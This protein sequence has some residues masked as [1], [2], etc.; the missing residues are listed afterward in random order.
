MP[1]EAK[2][3]ISVINKNKGATADA[4]AI[5]ETTSGAIS[6][7]PKLVVDNRNNLTQTM[8]DENRLNLDRSVLEGIYQ[9]A[10][11]DL[12]NN[13]NIVRLFPDIELC[14]QILVSSILSPKKMTDIQLIYSLDK[15]MG[16]LPNVSSK[17]L[18]AIEEHIETEYKLEDLLPDIVR[19][20]LFDSGSYCMAVIP[21]ASVDELINADIVSSL[22]TEAYQV[23]ADKLLTE[24]TASA[25]IITHTPVERLTAGLPMPQKSLMDMMLGNSQIRITD[26]C[27]LLQFSS[28]KEKV[29]ASL[30]KKSMRSG[31]GFAAESADRINY[32]DV[33]RQRQVGTAVS[34]VSIVKDK[35]QTKRKSIG[36][37]MVVKFPAE[38]TIPVSIPGNE[39]EHIGYLVLL[40]ENGKPLD[41]N[42]NSDV[43]N[44]ATG[45]Y[46]QVNQSAASPIQT[47]YR[48]LILDETSPA[49]SN[50]LYH[51]Y[52]TVLEKQLYETVKSSLYG[53]NVKIAQTNDIYFMMYCRA[54]ADQ[55]TNI[56][57]I[58]KE[59][60]V[61]FSFYYTDLGIG[62]SLL[63]NLT[64]LSSL[65]AI[66]LFSRVMAEAKNAIDVT[67]V[68]IQLD[69]RDP[70]PRKTIKA[71]QD[72]VMKLRAGFFP[73][74][75]NNPT[76]L[77]QWIQR[78]GLRFGYSG[79]PDLPD[80][81]IDF[82]T[83]KIDHVS[84]SGETEENLRKQTIQALGLPPEVVDNAFSPE[85]ATS[86]VSNNMLLAKRVMIYRKKLC[87]DLKKM[88]GMFI[89]M[90]EML[91]DTLRGMIGE[92]LQEITPTL[93]EDQKALAQ[94]DK[95]T[96]IEQY[97]DRMAEA[98]DV[99]LP[100]AENTNLLNLTQEFEV[101]K[102]GL[103][104]V[105]DSILSTD[106]FAEDIAG[107]FNAHVD[108]V[109]NIFIHHLLRQ[110]CANNNYYPEALAFTNNVKEEVD[111]MI[112]VLTAHLNG[113]IRN[114]SLL[115]RMMQDIKAAA[116]KDLE[117][118][119]GEAGSDS[120]TDSSSS[121][122]TS[123]SG[124]DTGGGDDFDLGGDAEADLK[125]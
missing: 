102:D 72:G 3:L 121:S 111:N 6:I 24:M 28:V 105:V 86:V 50:Q 100:K 59:L 106:I 47:A 81:K 77:V 107:A 104:K 53:K 61:Y 83:S 19:E 22:S 71:A 41:T 30:I 27:K 90:D 25:N 32:L 95:E 70:D 48:N 9:S 84:N 31:L 93:N 124:G 119:D 68:D 56:L 55:K 112:E 74:G 35:S 99:S 94:N 11:N 21:E 73:V 110:W 62:K 18:K 60:M 67:K 125:F 80:V 78:A 43:L 17:L 65:R 109:K 123:D 89:Y 4:K 42:M 33:F 2:S 63:D 122:D 54:L 7:L 23:G 40:D 5:L 57:F 58:P 120:T 114:G 36:K 101:Y 51:I 52:R 79:H 14:A 118:V 69:P 97:I 103:S 96:F 15:E 39:K 8:T 46:T 87:A 45:M 10:K 98:V 66:L 49:D 91:R 20:A 37:P 85:F 116:A 115:L 82:D 92:H 1:Y 38:C 88:T 13:R 108:T 117:T 12:E 16:L 29:T 75:I 113:G 64:I 26:N 76:D 34:N 44:S